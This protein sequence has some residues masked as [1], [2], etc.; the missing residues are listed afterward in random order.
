MRVAQPWAGRR[1]GAT[2]IPRVGQKV[3]VDFLEGDPNQP[4]VTC[5]VYNADQMP[6]Y[7][8]NGLDPKHTNGPNVSG[9]KCCSTERVQG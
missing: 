4:I 5:T 7:L 2:F 6:P 3:I 8:G 9:I 1:W